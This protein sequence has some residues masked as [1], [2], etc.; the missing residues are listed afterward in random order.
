MRG[1]SLAQGFYVYMGR[2][3]DGLDDYSVRVLE[4]VVGNEHDIYD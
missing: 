3:S 4:M 2:R 1:D